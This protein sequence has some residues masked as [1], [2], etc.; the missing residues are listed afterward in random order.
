MT[1]RL[2]RTLAFGLLFLLLVPLIVGSATTYAE[3]QGPASRLRRVPPLPDGS[4]LMARPRGLDGLI[5]DTPRNVFLKMRGEPLVLVYAAQKRAGRDGMSA[6]LQRTYVQRLAKA[7]ERVVAELRALGIPVISTYQKVLNGVQVRARPSKFKALL[8]LP[9]VESIHPV[10]ILV[11]LRGDSVPHIG[12]PQVIQELGID[13]SDVDIGIIDTGVDY[14]H[15]DFGGPATE[16]AYAANDPTVITDTYQNELLFPTAKVVGGWDFAG[17]LYDASCSQEDEEAGKCTTIPD[18]DPDPMDRHGHGT[19]VAGIAAGMG[20]EVLHPGVAPGARIWALKV[21]GDQVGSTALAADAIEWAADPNGDGDISDAL[22]VI[23]MSLGSPYGGFGENDAEAMAIANFTAAGGVVVASAG[24][25]GDAPMISGAPAALPQAISVA[26]SYAPGEIALGLRVNSPESIAGEYEAV[27]AAFTPRL[28]DVGPI[29]A[30]VTYVGRGCDV[31]LPYDVDPAG[32][33]ALIDRGACRF[34]EKIQNAEEAG[35][36]AAIIANNVEGPPF[37]MGGDPIVNIPAVMISKADG[38]ILKSVMPDEQVNVTMSS[39]IVIPKP[40]L[41]DNMSG[42]SSRG[43]TYPFRDVEGQRVLAKPDLTAPGSNIFSALVDSG[44][45]GIAASG[46]SMS[47]P[48][49]AGVAALLKQLY[50]DWTPMELKALMMNTARPELYLDGNPEFGGGG[51]LAPITRQGAGLVDAFAAANS[52]V[53]AYAEPAVSVDFGFQAVSEATSYSREITVVNRGDSDATYTLSFAFRD[54]DDENAG[55]SVS[56]SDETISVPA[57][58]TASFEVNVEVDPATLKD[59]GLSGRFM[60]SGDALRDVE[61]DGY[62][63]LTPAGSDLAQEDGTLRVPFYLLPRKTAIIQTTVRSISLSDFGPEA[64]ATA[65]LANASSVPGIADVFTLVG[66]DPNEPESADNVDVRAVGV[67]NTFIEGLGNVLEFAFTTYD[68][69]VHPDMLEIDIFIDTDQDGNADA[70]LFN[71]DLGALLGRGLNGQNVT[72]LWNMVTGEVT[73]QFFT[74]SDLLTANIDLPVLAEDMGLSSDNLTFNYWVAVFDL[75]DDSLADVLPDEAFATPAHYRFD[76]AHPLYVIEPASLVV[77]DTAGV[78]VFADPL[79]ALSA[80][81]AEGLLVLYSNNPPGQAEANVIPI[82]F[83]YEL[84]EVTIEASRAATGYVTSKNPRG[85]TLGGAPMWTGRTEGRHTWYGITQFDLTSQLPENARIVAAIVDLRGLDDRYLAPDRDATWT[86]ELLPEAL[87]SAWPRVNW[88]Q[89]NRAR[90]TAVLSPALS[91]DDLG[92]GI[93]NR[94]TLEGDQV[95]ALQQRLAT[96]GRASFRT[97]MELA[98]GSKLAY[99]H[100]FGW[101]GGGN[102]ERGTQVPVMRVVYT[103]VT[104]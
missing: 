46:T 7:Q 86:L 51:T 16:E 37:T 79:G 13:G 57:G 28:E 78:S 56:L 99:R 23:N 67:R 5:D 1:K 59:W 68:Y 44:T 66:E 20:N 18:P 102:R 2:Q 3:P 93:V 62:V 9:G 52:N 6:A 98:P 29:T 10:R 97:N 14:I 45:G 19:H 83:A 38:E 88:L 65:E 95:A 72:V 82:Q 35:A 54:P 17:V 84:K 25:S 92:P 87:D 48:H 55:V 85:A 100:V 94:F 53:I 24:N 101:D 36:V 50:P 27:E 49:V 76:G 96:T 58:G 12:S 4:V 64:G 32:T 74:V 15:Q 30:N 69:R 81:T 63:T 75:A 47:S 33:I 89:I 73:L 42:F 11:P 26:S 80:P 61:Y 40:E 21:F 43:P 60:G 34:D 70:I 8:A 31:D 104:P 71:G 90:A 39:D 41:T 22:D 91:D 103:T 77:T